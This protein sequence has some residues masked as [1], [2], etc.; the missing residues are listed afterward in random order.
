M[1]VIMYLENGTSDLTVFFYTAR[2]ESQAKA[3]KRIY[4]VKK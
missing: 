1:F 3:S 4:G 2:K